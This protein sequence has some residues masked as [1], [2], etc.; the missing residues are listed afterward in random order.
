MAKE[1]TVH[2]ID[3][4]EGG[5]SDFI[6]WGTTDTGKRVKFWLTQETIT[7][8]SEIT[9]I[10]GSPGHAMWHRRDNSKMPCEM[11]TGVERAQ[12]EE[13]ELKMALLDPEQEGEEYEGKSAGLLAE[14]QAIKTKLLR[15]KGISL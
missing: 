8:L 7:E 13:L 3:Y 9:K 10:A 14:I 2:K 6:F 12:V 5:V 11:C 1:L 15:E 4:I